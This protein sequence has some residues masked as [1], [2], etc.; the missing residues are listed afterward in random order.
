MNFI[1]NQLLKMT[2]HW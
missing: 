1:R 2:N